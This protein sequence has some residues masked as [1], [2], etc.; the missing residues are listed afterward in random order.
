MRFSSSVDHF[1]L[2]PTAAASYSA[3]S[4]ALLHL[5]KQHGVTLF[6]PVSGAGSSVEDARAAD[7]MFKQTQGTCQ[8][9]IQDPETM[10]DLHDKDRFMQL[11]SKLGLS[12]PSGKMVESVDEAMEFLRGEEREPRFVLKCMGLDENRGDMTLFPLW[13]DDEKLSNTRKWL[14]GLKLGI[15]PDCPYVF[16]EFIP[17]QG[18]CPF[19]FSSTGHTLDHHGLRLTAEWCTHASVIDGRIT[20][21]VTCPSNDMLMTYEN[22][23]TQPIGQ[24]AELWTQQFLSRLQ[25]DPTSTGRRRALTGHFSF[26]FIESTRNGELYPLECNARVHTAVIMLPLSGIADCYD[27]KINREILRPPKNAAPRSWIYNDLIMRYLP[28]FCPR[29]DILAAI[30]PSLPGS[31]VLPSKM[32]S[33]QPREDPWVWRK[34]PTLVRDDWVPFIVLWHVYWPALLLTRWW[35][36]KKW[37]RVSNSLGWSPCANTTAQRQYWP[38]LRSVR[39]IGLS[40]G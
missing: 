2:L 18:V 33:I 27:P 28:H 30:H 37:T 21:F 29:A 19:N 39:C 31:R 3:Y 4:S 40:S 23:T 7:E 15:T 16:Q 10:L 20:S 13:G 25:N 38:N 35:K 32:K 17:G 22:A 8:T 34:D 26:D 5:A 9:F 12:I 1:H 14:D 11:V 24:R 36:G 6:I